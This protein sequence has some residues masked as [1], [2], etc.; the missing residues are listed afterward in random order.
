MKIGGFL[1]T[2]LV[3]YPNK[4]SSVI[5]TQGCNFNC[6][7]CH[8]PGLTEPGLFNNLVPEKE[9]LDFLIRRSEQIEG[10]VLTGGEPTIQKDLIS[11]IKQI[12][13]MDYFV[14]L[15]TNGS[16]PDVLKEIIGL[17]LL[18]YIAMDIKAPL[19]KY[20]KY[21][22][23]KTMGLKIR[24]SITQSIISILYNINLTNSFTHPLYLS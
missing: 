17:K 23:Q 11:F 21:S 12:K 5:F 7:Y 24:K 10:V 22:G 9:I 2:S 6:G 16:N 19:S 15:N 13:D 20:P 8:N 1:K 14:K 18:D 3:D 4:V